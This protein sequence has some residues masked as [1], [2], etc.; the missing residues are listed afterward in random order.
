MN[1]EETTKNTA[2]KYGEFLGVI[3][4]LYQL[5]NGRGLPDSLRDL[6][7]NP[8]NAY[9]KIVSFYKT[10]LACPKLPDEYEHMIAQLSAD[11]IPNLPEKWT[12]TDK[13]NVLTG[14]SAMAV[15]LSKSHDNEKLEIKNLNEM[16]DLINNKIDHKYYLY[17]DEDNVLHAY[18]DSWLVE[19]GKWKYVGCYGRQFNESQSFTSQE[20]E[21]E[22]RCYLR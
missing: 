8:V 11:I 18:A 17:L 9:D 5:Q 13:C 15:E 14:C 19:P 3:D 22:I 7:R 10:V 16:V 12:D 6:N 1:R 2:Y 20:I 4:H 21:R